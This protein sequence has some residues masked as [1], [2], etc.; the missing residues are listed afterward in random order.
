MKNEKVYLWS[1]LPADIAVAQ[2][3]K[4]D[5]AFKALDAIEDK[6]SDAW[7]LEAQKLESVAKTKLAEKLWLD[8][9]N[10]KLLVR[11]ANGD[12]LD[13]DSKS[14]HLMGVKA[15]HL[16][17]TEGNLWLKENRYL[18]T[19]NPTAPPSATEAGKPWLVADPK[20]PTPAQSWYTPAR[21]FARELIRGDSTLLKKSLALA[22]K[23]SK[24]RQGRRL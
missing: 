6:D 21:Y 17:C 15:P 1:D 23:V 20:D 5:S 12:P 24:S 16:T 7:W 19:W 14:F 9:Y 11:D 22:D 2:G 8:I 13:G 3:M 4:S 18:H 10:G